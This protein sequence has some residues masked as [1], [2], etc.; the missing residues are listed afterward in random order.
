MGAVSRGDWSSEVGEGGEGAISTGDG[1]GED[2][3]VVC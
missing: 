3:Q 1:G 2:Q